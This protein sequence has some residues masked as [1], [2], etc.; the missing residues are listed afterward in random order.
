MKHENQQAIEKIEKG[1]KDEEDQRMRAENPI[2]LPLG[3]DPKVVERR[4]RFL[5]E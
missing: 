5:A 4:K 1:Y 3:E 2:K